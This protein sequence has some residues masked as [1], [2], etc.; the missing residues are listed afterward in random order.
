ML[1][2]L[3]SSMLEHATTSGSAAHADTMHTHVLVH[4]RLLYCHALPETVNV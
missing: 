3:L 1:Q 2:E 4:M